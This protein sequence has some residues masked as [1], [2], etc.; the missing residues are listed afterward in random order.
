MAEGRPGPSKAKKPRATFKNP[1]RLTDEEL[2]NA[3]MYSSDEDDDFLGE[4]GNLSDT[5]ADILLEQGVSDSEEDDTDDDD[6]DRETSSQPE[7]AEADE[8][9]GADADENIPN[10]TDDHMDM[11]DFPFTKNNELLVPIPDGNKPINYFRMIFDDVFLNLIVEETNHYAEEVF[12]G[13]GVSEKSRITRWKPVTADEMLTFVALLLHTGTIKLNRLHDY[14]KGH[15][16]FNLKCFS[17]HMSRDRFLLILRCLHFVRNPADGERPNDRLYK[18]RPVIN[19]FNDKISTIYYPGKELSLDESMVL[20]RGRLIFRQYIKNKRHK[21]G[22]KL[23]MLTE[24]NGIV[25]NSMVYTGALDDSGE[26][27]HTK[28]VVLNLLKDYFGS[29]HSVY[30]DN[31]YNS[32]ELANDLTKRENYCT[33]TL[34]K[35]RK[36]NPEEVVVKK[37]KKGETVAR[38]ANNTMIGKWKDKRDVLY[39]SNEYQ[40]DMVEYVD[41]RNRTK[42]K[43]VPIFHYNKHMG[44]VDRQNQLN[45]YYPCERKCIRWY[46]KLGI[47]F[48]PTHA[49]ECI[50]AA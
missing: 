37:L 50:F 2:L 45:S 30:M 19:F 41:K 13:V 3:L 47:H 20:W 27:G 35:K 25:L 48:F 28:K 15:P 44:G 6:E 1:K 23:Y 14:W 5:E 4:L 24:P 40:N 31:F 34:S 36:N 16:L 32:Y 12:L 29:G 49:I 18:I 10:W 39:I 8:P 22:I 43:P 17:V 21:Y 33:G 9:M 11:K 42:E 26:K 46:K 7:V 38:Y